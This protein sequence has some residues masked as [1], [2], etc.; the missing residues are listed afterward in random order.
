MLIGALAVL[1]HAP[2]HLWPVTIVCFAILMNRLD[3][4]RNKSAGGF[5][6]GFWFGLGYFL[7]GTFWIGSAFIVRGPEFIPAM[8]P[9]I[10][11]LAALLAFFW[12]ITGWL[13][14]RLFGSGL[15]RWAGLAALLTIAEFAR[16]HVLL[17]GPPGTAK[18]LLARSFASAP[19]TRPGLP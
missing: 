14:T 2:F 11:G 4:A 5:G 16:G 6:R 9:M 17:E 13:Y 8:P 12:G 15:L 7:F 3:F 10:L 1:G 19:V 18:T